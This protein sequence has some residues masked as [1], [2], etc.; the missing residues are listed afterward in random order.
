M[1]I[2]FDQQVFMIFFAI[3]WGTVANVQPR[4]K[5]FQFPLMFKLP[6]VCCRVQLSILLLNLLPIVYFGYVLWF[7][8][9]RGPTDT[10]TKFLVVAK[11]LI[12]GILPAFGMFGF[13]RMWL[14]IVELRPELF[15]KYTPDK[16]PEKY[17]CVE[18]T[19]RLGPNKDTTK[20]TITMPVVDLGEDTGKGNI[21]AASI[22]LIVGGLSPWLLRW[23]L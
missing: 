17:R 6:N 15:Y 14:G 7:T 1:Q 5:A 20:D 4:W 11:V 18:P 8:Y 23:L 10:D 22:Y 12:Q 19:Y 13:Y 2:G 16:L 9:G 21:V 3:F